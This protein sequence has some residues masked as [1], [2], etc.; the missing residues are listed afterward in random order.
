MCVPR[1]QTSYAPK[2]KIGVPLR[3]LL[4]KM[5]TEV[6]VRIK[7]DSDVSLGSLHAQSPGLYSLGS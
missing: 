4:Q 6:R 1:S 2:L 5:A 3:S 7:L